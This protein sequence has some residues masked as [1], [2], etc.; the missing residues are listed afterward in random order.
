MINPINKIKCYDLALKKAEFKNH[1]NYGDKNKILIWNQR[2]PYKYCSLDYL[3]LRNT[4][5]VINEFDVISAFIEGGNI[6]KKTL[7][8]NSIHIRCQ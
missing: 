7:F 3:T 5:N 2:I 4:L 8:I 6:I 1:L